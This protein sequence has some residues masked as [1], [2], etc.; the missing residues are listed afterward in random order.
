MKSN[1]LMSR[2]FNVGWVLNSETKSYS[3]RKRLFYRLA[4]GNTHLYFLLVSEAIWKKNSIN[5]FAC[6]VWDNLKL[7]QKLKRTSVFLSSLILNDIMYFDVIH[8]CILVCMQVFCH[9]IIHKMYTVL[10]NYWRF[11]IMTNFVYQPNLIKLAT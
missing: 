5:I 10:Y 2:V 9:V 8:K 6:G 3:R 7:F 4:N 11:C 1:D